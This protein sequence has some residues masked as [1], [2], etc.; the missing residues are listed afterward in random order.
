MHS[1]N[2]I[3]LIIL[4]IFN[5]KYFKIYTKLVIKNTSKSITNTITSFY[6]I[7]IIIKSNRK[8]IISIEKNNNIGIPI[9]TYIKLA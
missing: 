2:R 6:S 1:N 4:V 8:I 7:N 9:A 3:K 5:E